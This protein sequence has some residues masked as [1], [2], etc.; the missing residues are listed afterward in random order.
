MHTPTDRETGAFLLVLALRTLLALAVGAL[1]GAVA[2]W[3][4]GP[5]PTTFAVVSLWIAAIAAFPAAFVVPF[6][7]T[8]PLPHGLLEY[9]WRLARAVRQHPPGARRS[10]AAWPPGSK[11]WTLHSALLAGMEAGARGRARDHERILRAAA[12]VVA[13]GG[14]RAGDMSSRHGWARLSAY[15]MIFD[16]LRALHR[17]AEIEPYAWAAVA[18]F[19]IPA[20]RALWC[21]ETL[22]VVRRLWRERW[23]AGERTP[24][25]GR[26][27][28]V[29]T[30]G[31]PWQEE[32]L[33]EAVAAGLP[34]RLPLVRMPAVGP[35]EREELA[36]AGLGTEP[37]LLGDLVGLLGAAD[38]LDE[39]INLAR[40]EEQRGNPFG[41]EQLD[42]AGQW[43]HRGHDPGVRRPVAARGS[44]P[45]W[46]GGS[47]SHLANWSVSDNAGAA[48]ALASGSFG[49]GPGAG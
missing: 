7:S 32:F 48:G 49:S 2:V 19:G 45:G 36:R 17:T 28:L 22:A 20:R 38:R 33:R 30:E 39:A 3:L 35:A 40:D 37:E 42:R 23:A 13:T 41:A 47:Y 43:R 18:E 14:D 10:M 11:A 27:L 15:P 6:A 26:C 16:A 44:A 12:R 25:L 9:R 8:R 46:S 34:F 31:D 21:P 4:R 1:G 29:V 24:E 5:D